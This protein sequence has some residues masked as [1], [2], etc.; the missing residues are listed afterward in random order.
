MS[1]AMTLIL[2]RGRGVPPRE[3]KKEK[4]RRDA[5]A[6]DCTQNENVLLSVQ[7]VSFGMRMTAMAPSGFAV[8]GMSLQTPPGPDPPENP[9]PYQSIPLK[10]QSPISK[11]QSP[12][13]NPVPYQ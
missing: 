12:I 10:I 13:S 11:I 4:L 7:R 6:T 3:L 5:S 9:V 1:V 2:S 8:T